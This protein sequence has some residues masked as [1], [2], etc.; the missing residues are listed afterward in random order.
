LAS[1]G[2]GRITLLYGAKDPAINHAVVLADFLQRRI[3]SGP[4]RQS[5]SRNVKPQGAESS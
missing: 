2:G 1:L 3:A 5:A 4:A